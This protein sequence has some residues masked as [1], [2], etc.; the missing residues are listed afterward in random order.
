[1]DAA[2]LLPVAGAVILLLPIAWEPAATPAPDTARGLIYLFG[3]WAMLILGA[4][5]LA[6]GLAPTYDEEETAEGSAGQGAMRLSSVPPP[7]E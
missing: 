4:L 3:S 7:E 2:R 1:M 6:R 5:I